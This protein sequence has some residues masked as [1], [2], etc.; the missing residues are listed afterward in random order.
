MKYL[1]VLLLIT[2]LTKAELQYA[3]FKLELNTE[4]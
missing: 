1:K 4:D 2:D 3:I